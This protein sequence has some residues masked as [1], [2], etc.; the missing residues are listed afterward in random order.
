MKNRI[1]KMTKNL[2]VQIEGETVKTNIWMSEGA[3]KVLTAFDKEK[4]CYVYRFPEEK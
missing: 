4:N 2:V 3:K 1:N